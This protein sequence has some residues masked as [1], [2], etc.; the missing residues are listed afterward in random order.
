MQTT[1]NDNKNKNNIESNNNNDVVGLILSMSC[2]VFWEYEIPV[3]VN[4]RQF[5]IKYT[6]QTEEEAFQSLSE[7]LCNHM[8]MHIQDCLINEGRRDKL[9][10]LEQIF[11]KFHI[12]G[13]TSHE[14]LYPNDPSNSD[15][16]RGD[17]K[18]FICTHC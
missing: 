9:S 12:H 7:F 15:H 8:K 5:S 17:S 3:K 18:I 4:R 14:I 1:T 2:D 16:C 6:N 10:T 13:L 11:P